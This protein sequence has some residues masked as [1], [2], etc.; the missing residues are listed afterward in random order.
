LGI[1]AVFLA[2]RP[3]EITEP[4]APKFL[5]A[6]PAKPPDEIP[7]TRQR[8]RKS[9]KTKVVPFPT[10]TPLTPEEKALVEFVA[11]RPKEAQDLLAQTDIKPIEIEEIQ[12]PPL[13]SDGG[14]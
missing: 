8:H 11:N 6:A 13:P 3:T 10:P 7:V 12:V 1:A 5:A 14:K 4:P 9:A 2:P